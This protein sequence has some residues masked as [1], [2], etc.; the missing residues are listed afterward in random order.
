MENNRD[1]MSTI[2]QLPSEI[3][4][5]RARESDFSKMQEGDTDSMHGRRD[6]LHLVLDD[7]QNKGE[8]E[9]W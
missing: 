5:R 4:N 2:L 8:V 1:Q 3:T 6:S 7:I 9:D